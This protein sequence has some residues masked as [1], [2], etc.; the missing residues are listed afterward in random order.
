MP[1]NDNTYKG[2]T[3]AICAGVRRKFN[4]FKGNSDRKEA[5]RVSMK[6]NSNSNSNSNNSNVSSDSHSDNEKTLIIRNN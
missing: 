3:K 2:Y 4:I 1:A 5:F 6:M